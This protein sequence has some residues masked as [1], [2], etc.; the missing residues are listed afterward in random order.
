[1]STEIIGL[2]HE[3]RE[4]VANVVRFNHMEFESYEEIA[5]SHLMT[6][7]EYLRITKLAA[8]LRVANG[9]DRSHKQKFKNI[10]VSIK[11]KDLIITVKTDKDITLERGLLNERANF[12]EDV[13]YLKPVIK[14]QNEK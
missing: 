13:F 3:E 12:F 14:Q 6:P 9:L 7:N 8:I 5:G 4:I 1:M 10:K 2:S 11:E